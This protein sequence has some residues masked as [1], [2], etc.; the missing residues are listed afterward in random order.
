MGVNRY[1]DDEQATPPLQRIDPRMEREQVARLQRLRS[2]RDARIWAAALDRLGE[3]AAG[4]ENLVPP[5]ID[6]VKAYA[7][8]GEIC[9]ALKDVF[10]EYEEPLEL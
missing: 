1:L 5:I 4:T 3:A 2:E 7:T 9:T 8:V 6:A 10:G